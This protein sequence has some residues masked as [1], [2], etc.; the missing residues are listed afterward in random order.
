MVTVASAIEACTYG[1]M[2]VDCLVCELSANSEALR[3][4]I[5]HT[6]TRD[7]YEVMKGHGQCLSTPTFWRNLLK[8]FRQQ[9][10]NEAVHISEETATVN[11]E[12]PVDGHHLRRFISQVPTRV[13]R[14]HVCQSMLETE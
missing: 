5:V 3:S 1:S 2:S 6:E 12:D 4:R 8:P 14:T 11:M 7:E 10:P 9:I 13:K